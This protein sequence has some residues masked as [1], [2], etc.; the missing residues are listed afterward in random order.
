MHCTGI[1][2]GFLFPFNNDFVAVA[3]HIQDSF[4]AVVAPYCLEVHVA[5]EPLTADFAS[6]SAYFAVVAV[7]AVV[8][9]FP[10]VAF[11]SSVG[12]IQVHP[13]VHPDLPCTHLDLHGNFDFEVASYFDLH[14]LASVDLLAA[15]KTGLGLDLGN[16]PGNSDLE[17]SCTV[18]EVLAEDLN[19]GTWRYLAYGSY[20]AS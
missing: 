20:L 11:D 15:Y 17:S 5:I 10:V 8:V 16:S 1:C 3:A 2:K 13:E 4:V 14:N 18:V 19:L 6:A 12:D 7:A 9:D